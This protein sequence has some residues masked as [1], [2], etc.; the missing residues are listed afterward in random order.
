MIKNKPKIAVIGLKGLPAFGGAA[1]VGENIITQL[2]D[3]YDFTVLSVASHT[4]KENT[5]INGVRQIV[6]RNYGR[7]GINTFIYYLNCLAHVLI[8][9]YDLVHL[10]HAESGFITP[11][12]KLRNEVVV[13]FHG[14]SFYKD[15]KFTRLHNRFFRFSER[16]NILFANKVVSVSKPDT[17][18][19][20]QKYKRII[21]YIPNGISYMNI[22]GSVKNQQKREEYILFAAGRI[23][24]I[25]GLHLLLKAAHR[26]DHP[27]KLIVA[28]DVD[29]VPGYRT[30]IAKLSSGLQIEYLGLIKEKSKLLQLIKESK[31]FVF[32]SITEAM[33]MMLLEVVSMKISVIASDIPSN[34]AIF[35]NDDVLF[36]KSDDVEDLTTKLNYALENSFEMRKKAEHAYELIAKHY[37]WE[38]I[39]HEYSKIYKMLIK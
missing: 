39:S 12:L 34:K 31:L 33:S 2:K 8:N 28:G 14:I 9:K 27:I 24:P 23:I 37:T 19:I 22:Q 17:D 36:F 11:F 18:Y 25:K 29:Q 32:P 30:N 35:T 26:I 10:H 5:N 6:F 7:G 20:Y 21:E 15:S 38:T 4:E 16:L 3:K 13:T 1:A